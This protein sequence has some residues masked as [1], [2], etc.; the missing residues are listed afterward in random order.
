[1]LSVQVHSET[2]ASLA[3]SWNCR[4]RYQ[5]QCWPY[6]SEIPEV[7]VFPYLKRVLV[8]YLMPTTTQVTSVG[9]NMA[10]G[11]QSSSF[12]ARNSY[13]RGRFWAKSAALGSVRWC[14]FRSC[15]TVLSHVVRGQH[16]C[17][18]SWLPVF[19]AK[20]PNYTAWWLMSDNMQKTCLE[21][22][23]DKG[24]ARNQ[25]CNLLIAPTFTQ[26]SIAF[27][28]TSTTD[29]TGLALRVKDQSK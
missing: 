28:A 1:M 19:S 24:I 17:L 22:L 15:W 23:Y 16:S 14:C 21:S 13:H 4:Q 9:G 7:S 20:L 25:T 5:Q 11:C 12:L 26:R 10:A 8:L 18:P 3:S 27:S 2:D 29:R 6:I